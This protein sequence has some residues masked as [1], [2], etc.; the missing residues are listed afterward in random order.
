MNRRNI[1][2]GTGA[3]AFLPLVLGQKLF[4]QDTPNITPDTVYELSVYHLHEGKLPLLLDRFTNNAQ[5][6]FTRHNMHPVAYWV[7]TD[8]PLAG[9]TFIYILRH[10]SRDAA[11]ANWAKFRADPDWIALRAHTEKD[12]PFI[13][14]DDSTF[15]KLTDFSPQI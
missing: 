15:M 9:C 7:P 5:R 10:P 1:L 3:A 2:K 8:P 11:D 6:L 13:I 14:S 4:A 12:G